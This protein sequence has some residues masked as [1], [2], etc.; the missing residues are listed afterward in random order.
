MSDTLPDLPALVTPEG[1]P[2]NQYVV[3]AIH[4]NIVHQVFFLDGQTAALFAANPTFVHIAKGQAQVGDEYDP[5]AGTFTTPA[6]TPV[7]P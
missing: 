5:V 6:V 2:A 3:A 1:M 4:E 7:T